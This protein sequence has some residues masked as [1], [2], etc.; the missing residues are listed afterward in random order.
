MIVLWSALALGAPEWTPVLDQDAY[1]FCTDPGAQADS[2]RDWCPML[3]DAPPDACPGLRKTCEGAPARS[4]VRDLMER[5]RGCAEDSGGRL[6]APPERPAKGCD[7]DLQPKECS[8]PPD[9]TTASGLARWIGAIAVAVLVLIVLRVLAAWWQWRR[10]D[11]GSV[12]ITDPIAAVV[13]DPNTI[14]DL[15]S[16]DLLGAARRALA[17]GRYDE[18]ALLARA[19]ALR[20]LGEAGRVVLHRARTDR[21][22]A[23]SVRDE[24]DVYDPLRVI[25]SI[26]EGLRWGGRAI[27]VESARS[28]LEAAE[29]V[30]AALIVAL[31]VLGATEREARAGRYD[32]YGDAGLRDL[33]DTG[34]YVVSWRLRGLQTLTAGETDVLVL[35]LGQIAPEPADDEAIRAWVDA[36]GLLVVGGDASILFPELGFF[37]TS[38]GGADTDTD[39]GPTLGFADVRLPD[40]SPF[41][42]P[43]AW[44]WGPGAAW[45]SATTAVP[46][47]IAD[48]PTG[49]VYPIV[50]M[51]VGKGGVIAIAD[52]RLLNNGALVSPANEAFLLQSPYAGHDAGLWRL[53]LPARVQLATRSGADSQDPCGTLARAHL[54][55][56]VIQLLLIAV[57]VGMWRG[58]AFA[59]LRDPPEAGR[60][61]FSEHVRALGARYFRAKATRPAFGAS[62]ALWLGRLGR[63]GIIH[64]GTRAGLAPDKANALADA[65]E[66]AAREPFGKNQ[67]EDL[68]NMEEL[69]RIVQHRS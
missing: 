31:V 42:A 9:P 49:D 11:R 38:E 25:L 1:R 54:L 39:A 8:T 30:V 35:D 28:A 59:P 24:A 52:D 60:L 65:A 67:P 64:A 61:A 62:A 68:A 32:P 23:R 48:G 21:E 43:P 37:V 10:A 22:Y 56:A 18:A 27:G 55:P 13:A 44:P 58:A 17:E 63:N 41:Q 12:V 19:T 14:P 50:A 29:R 57:L 47:V 7:T 53:A 33:Y 40:R 69:W 3:A 16:D 26:V 6:A 66:A 46:W 15:P 45:S 2:A 5:L 20:R 51:T 34:G 36:G 4:D